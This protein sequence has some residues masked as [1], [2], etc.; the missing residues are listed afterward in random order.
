MTEALNIWG[1]FSTID[2]TRLPLPAVLR[3]T[4]AAKKE[5]HRLE[6]VGMQ[7]GMAT[8]PNSTSNCLLQ[9][10]KTDKTNDTHDATN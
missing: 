10:H 2:A 1:T 4:Y 3:V 9:L 7:I 6:V 8:P 5:S